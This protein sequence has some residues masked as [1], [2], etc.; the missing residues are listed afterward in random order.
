[1]PNQSV[2]GLALVLLGQHHPLVPSQ[3]R[4]QQQGTAAG[5]A[6]WGDN[7][8]QITDNLLKN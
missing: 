8:P 4:D 3:P 1:M 2:L 5:G 7:K 6:H